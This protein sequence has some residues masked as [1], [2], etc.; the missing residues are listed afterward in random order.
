M[1]LLSEQLVIACSSLSSGRTLIFSLFQVNMSID[2]ATYQVLFMQ[3]FIG[4]A[5]S[6][7]TLWP[8]LVPSHLFT[9]S[10]SVFSSRSCVE[11]VFIVACIP[12]FH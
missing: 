10:S 4:D 8:S 5:I 1:Q 6:Q 2:T 3:P 11:D 9:F 12:M 7:Q